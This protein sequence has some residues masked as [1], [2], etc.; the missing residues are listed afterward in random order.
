MAIRDVFLPLVGEPSAAALAAI[1]KCVAVSS[2]FG[3]KMSAVAIEEDIP[4]RPKVISSDLD[5]SAA[6][7]AVRSVTDAHGLL[8]AF[9]S[10]AVRFGLRNEHKLM[11]WPTADIP[12]NVA[13]YARLKDMSSV[14]MTANRKRSSS[15]CCSSRAGRS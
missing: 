7:E 3:A 6:T 10:A 2:D 5:N 8:K 12:S 9:D 1:E 4:V 11:R 15:N 13:E 14:R